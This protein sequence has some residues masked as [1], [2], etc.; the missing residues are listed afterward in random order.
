MRTSALMEIIFPDGAKRNFV[1]GVDADGNGTMRTADT[2]IVW[3]AKRR[4]IMAKDEWRYDV[5]APEP[6]WWWGDLQRGG[7]NFGDRPQKP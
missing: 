2:C 7:G 4:T 6:E 1:Y 3:D 5:K